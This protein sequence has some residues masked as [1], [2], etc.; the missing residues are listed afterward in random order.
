[1]V[2]CFAC[3]CVE[4]DEE[5]ACEGDPHDHLFRA[6]GEEPVAKGGEVVVVFSGDVGDEEEDGADRGPAA[7]DTTPSMAGAAVIGDGGNACQL[8]DGL[9]R[10]GA[11]FGQ[12]S[13]Q[14]G[15]GAI[16][17]AVDRTDG[18]VERDPDRIDADQRRDLG[19]ERLGLAWRLK[20]AI[21]SLR[22]ASAVAS[23]VAW[24]RCFWIERSAETWR[25]RAT[26]AVSRR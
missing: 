24:S 21:V 25:K 12:F 1:M 15:D 22:L 2:A 23:L 13:E 14:D 6:L 4:A 7:A 20:K 8:D 16:G 17:E 11:E 19:R 9:A 5:F 26:S 18:P 10:E 3:F